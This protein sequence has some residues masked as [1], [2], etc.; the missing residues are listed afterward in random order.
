MN[1]IE[2]DGKIYV[3]CKV[4]SYHIENNL[5]NTIN[6]DLFNP[7]NIYGVKIEVPESSIDQ[8]IQHIKKLGMNFEGFKYIISKS[9]FTPSEQQSQLITIKNENITEESWRSFPINPFDYK[10]ATQ[11]IDSQ[12]DIP[13]RFHFESNQFNEHKNSFTIAV[14]PKTSI[15]LIF[16]VS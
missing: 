8:I 2:Q 4:F 7:E 11:M 1:N 10:K 12:I 3:D 13:Y 14:L 9:V 16:K 15:I 5:Y 6:I